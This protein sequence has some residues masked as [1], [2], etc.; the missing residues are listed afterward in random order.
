MYRSER[1]TIRQVLG[2]AK[3]Y[4]VGVIYWDD[5]Q[6]D[7]E[8]PTVAIRGYGTMSIDFL[9]ENIANELAELSKKTKTGGLDI[10]ANHFLLDEKSA[11]MYK[12]KAYMDVKQE[13]S[14]SKVK[15]KLTMMKKK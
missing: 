2:E 15:R 12:V 1:N 13:L 4:G 10:V 8:N 5:P 3:G 14:S 6:F 11:F 9:Q 7:P